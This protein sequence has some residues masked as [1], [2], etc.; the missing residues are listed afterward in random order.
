MQGFG[1]SAINEVREQLRPWPLKATSAGRAWEG[2]HIDEFAEFYLEDYFSPP[3]DHANIAVCLGSSPLMVQK[4]GGKTFASPSRVGEFSIN[5]AGHESYWNGMAPAHINI[6]PDPH[7]LD[8]LASDLRRVGA[9][10]FQFVNVFRLRDPTI[11][12]F[13]RLFHLELNR[14]PHPVQE[15]L[16]GSLAVALSAHLLRGYTN[17]VGI[18]ARSS[19]STDLACLNRAIAYIEDHPD[20]A[21]SLAELAGAAGVSRFHFSRLFRS[22][23]GQTAMQYVERSR[24]ERA[25]LLIM[26]AELSLADVAQVIG[27]ADQSHF[28]RR[29]RR[30]E[31]RT[32]GQFAREHARGVLPK[33][34]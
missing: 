26:Q 15:L 30:H 28:T 25:K 20:R 9:P 13:A 18:E 27:F 5:P 1:L 8:E 21:I 19:A 6:R 31:G 3:R 12:Q 11:E 10:R 17:A 22:K 34:R 2:V 7:K 23:F 29:F 32:P 24:I 33:D 4:R 14:A 16:I